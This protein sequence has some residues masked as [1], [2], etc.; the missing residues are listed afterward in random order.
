MME[1][2]IENLRTD[3]S[4]INVNTTALD[5]N[6]QRLLK[7]KETIENGELIKQAKGKCLLDMIDKITVNPNAEITIYYNKYKLLGLVE[8]INLGND[9]KEEYKTTVEYDGRR[10][11]KERTNSEKRRLIEEIRKEGRRSYAQYG[12]LL[13][14]SKTDVGARM[15]ELFNRGCISRNEFGELSV[16]KDWTDEW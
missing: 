13:G 10:S 5:I 7:I 12:E 8:F 6:E 11:L 1:T 14:I 4:L 2:K 15:K 9:G 3:I 16:I